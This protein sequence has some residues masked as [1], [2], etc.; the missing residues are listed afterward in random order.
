MEGSRAAVSQGRGLD[1]AYLYVTGIF[2]VALSLIPIFRGSFRVPYMIPLW[3]ALF[4]VYRYALV[5]EKYKFLVNGLFLGGCYLG[6]GYVASTSDGSCYGESILALET[7]LFGTLPSRWLQERLITRGSPNWYD[8]PLAIAHSLF[9][10]FPFITPWLVYRHRGLK[11]MK[12]AILA[13]G[14]ITTTGYLAYILFP[15]TPPW[16]LAIDGVIEPL[17]RCVFNAIREVVPAFLVSSASNTPRAAMPSLHAGVTLL[18]SL[19]LLRELGWK[20]GWWSVVILLAICFEIIYG[21]EHFIIDIAA[22]FL[23]ALAAYAFAYLPG[24]GRE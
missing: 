8:Y 6:L 22:G 18:M 1:V 11:A 16:L 9:F 10:S 13:F 12:R 7:R 24:F 17:D 4:L 19:L 15:L 23:F 5:P 3:A 21:A 2:T 20:R 14:F